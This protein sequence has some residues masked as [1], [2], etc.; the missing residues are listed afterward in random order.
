MILHCLSVKD[1]E[2]YKLGHASSF[3]Y[4][5]QSNTYDL[6]G[7]NNEDE[8]W[9][10][11]RAM[12]I[13]GIS[14]EDQV[15]NMML[16]H[17]DVSWKMSSSENCCVVL[18]LRSYFSIFQKMSLSLYLFRMLYFG[19]WQPFFILVILS[20]PQERIPILQKLRIQ[21]QIFISKRQLNYLCMYFC[22]IN[23]N[24]IFGENIPIFHYCC[25][26]GIMLSVLL[27]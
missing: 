17:L 4:L 15:P 12:D 22:F 8:Y 13:V 25:F 3:H 9:K 10:T 24:D 27:F 1:A 6:E 19:H 16:R 2:L 11:K 14:R 21:P 5:N 18:L 26:S 23:Y 20:L 7:T